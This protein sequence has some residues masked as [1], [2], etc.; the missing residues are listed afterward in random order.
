M[1][2]ISVEFDGL[3]AFK[4]NL[5]IVAD[6]ILAKASHSIDSYAENTMNISY[7]E[8]PVETGFLRNSQ[9]I[10]GNKVDGRTVETILAYDTRGAKELPTG[11]AV[12]QH[13]GYI[14]GKDGASHPIQ[15]HP[16][17][18]KSHFLSDPARRLF[19]T[20]VE[21]IK[22]SILENPTE[23]VSISTGDMRSGSRAVA[24]AAQDPMGINYDLK[25]ALEEQ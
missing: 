21:D 11:Y 19:P 7:D 17:G 3:D 6:N 16:M 2:Q 25:T 12:M 14:I 15:N 5:Q 18:G 10:H 1:V 22:N 24:T 20:L 13:E 8:V 23:P 4:K 9:M